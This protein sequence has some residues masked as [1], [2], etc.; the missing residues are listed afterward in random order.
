M[1]DNN[2][3]GAHHK[4]KTIIITLLYLGS[5]IILF[6]GIFFGAFSVLNN[7]QLKVL[8]ASIHGIVFGLLV[9]YL[10]IRY[11]F[12]VSDFK[13]VLYNSNHSFSWSNFKKDK[14]KRGLV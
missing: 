7:I 13:K 6:L 4:Q 12:M 14:S 2:S 11:F 9:A 10:G 1:N 5:L 3:K 8:S